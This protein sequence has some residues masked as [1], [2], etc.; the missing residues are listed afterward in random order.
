MADLGV[1]SGEGARP[2]GAPPP[3]AELDGDKVMTLVD[4]LAELR[5]RVVISILAVFVGSTIGFYFGPDII[6][7]LAQP[8]GGR[9]ITLHVGFLVA[10]PVVLYQLWAFVSPGLTP[11]ERQVARPWIPLAILFFLAGVAVAWVVLPYTVGFL[12]GFQ[13]DDIV[14]PSVTAENY[15]G[16]ITLMFGG[17]GIVMQFPIVLILLSK[18][19]LVS[20]ERLR[21]ARR[22]VLLGV[23]VVAVVITPGGDPISPLIL[24]GVMY[25][26][27]EF[28]IVLLVRGRRQARG[29]VDG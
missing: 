17:F 28:T 26:L 18:L 1:V 12:M 13:I 11:R 3:P 7:L 19:G 27:Y 6:R 20:V 15:F 23:F 29:D 22:Y 2:L 24:G 4:H 9:L 16:F 14:I 10:F 5:R 25:L 21:A 8:I